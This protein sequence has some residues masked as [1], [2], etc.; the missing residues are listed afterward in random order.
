MSNFS[1]P[2]TMAMTAAASRMTTISFWNPAAEAAPL[3][4]MKVMMAATTTPMMMPP[5]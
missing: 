4:F 1:R 5:K 2:Q 3:M